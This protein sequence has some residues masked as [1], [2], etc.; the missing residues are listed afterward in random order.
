MNFLDSNIQTLF[1]LILIIIDIYTIHQFL[2]IIF[3]KM[4]NNIPLT[5]MP[6]EVLLVFSLI[7]ILVII[8]GLAEYEINHLQSFFAIFLNP[9]IAFSYCKIFHIPSNL[10]STELDF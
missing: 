8:G 7:G 9:F 10:N 6:A 3:R 1:F 2:R 5:H 4:D